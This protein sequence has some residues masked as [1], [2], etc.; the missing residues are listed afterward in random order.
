M[1]GAGTATFTD[2][3]DYQARLTGTNI[4]LVLTGGGEF[5]AR[6]TWVE[7][8]RLRLFHA[9]ESAA[10]IAFVKWAPGAVFVAFPTSFSPPQIWGGEKLSPGDIVLH[11]L[12][13]SIHQRTSGDSQ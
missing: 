12:G 13:D 10:R 3:G 2:P 4:N 1:I 8:R 7:L 5:K 6:L 9:R 11:S